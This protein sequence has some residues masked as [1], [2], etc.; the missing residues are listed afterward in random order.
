LNSSL[1]AD[2]CL[3]VAADL[4]PHRER[5]LT[6][7]GLSQ[8]R[9]ALLRGRLGVVER[10]Q[11]HSQYAWTPAAETPLGR[12]VT[13]V[14][15]EQQPTLDQPLPKRLLAERHGLAGSQQLLDDHPA[16]GPRQQVDALVDPRVDPTNVLDP[17]FR[18]EG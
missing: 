11:W 12:V 1:D 16:G 3:D 7:V 9:C 18:R 14:A 4:S 13:R 5:L 10:P 15:G 2:L 17:E 6:P 8:T